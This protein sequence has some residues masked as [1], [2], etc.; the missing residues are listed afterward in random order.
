MSGDTDTIRVGDRVRSTNDGQLGVVVRTDTG[1]G[2]KLD[3]RGEERILPWRSSQW[4]AAESHTPLTDLQVARI[5]HAAD[6]AWRQVHGEYQVVDWIAL[7]DEERRAWLFGPP[8]EADGRRR[9]LYETVRKV[10][11]SK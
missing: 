2:V 9:R 5:C 4:I 8:K 6:R 1:Y 3:R 11:T 10:V 7:R